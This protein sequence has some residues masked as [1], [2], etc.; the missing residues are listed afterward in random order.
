MTLVLIGFAVVLGFVAGLLVGRKNPKVA[1]SA[2]DLADEI[3]KATG[4]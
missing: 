3:K 1:T 4:Q 2:Q